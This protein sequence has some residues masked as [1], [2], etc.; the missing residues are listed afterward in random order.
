VSNYTHEE[1]EEYCAENKH[2]FLPFSPFLA[3][4]L[5]DSMGWGQLIWRVTHFNSSVTDALETM[6]A[7][8]QDM[9]FLS[10]DD[11]PDMICRLSLIRLSMRPIPR[12]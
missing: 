5:E 3:E 6:K 12:Q 7:L 2:L 4:P 8:G 9:N 11:A 1:L 10:D